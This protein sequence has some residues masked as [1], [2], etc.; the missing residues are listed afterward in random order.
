M[1]DILG[2][3]VGRGDIIVYGNTRLSNFNKNTR[4]EFGVVSKIITGGRQYPMKDMHTKQPV[5]DPYG[6]P[7]MITT[8]DKIVFYPLQETDANL[9]NP[10]YDRYKNGRPKHR[11]VMFTTTCVKFN[12]E[13]L[14]P[15]WKDAYNTFRQE[16]KV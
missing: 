8:I 3:E 14:T 11:R 4:S 5:L 1:L 9:I 2:R 13:D 10:G 7:F 15:H 16:F 6:N 12:V